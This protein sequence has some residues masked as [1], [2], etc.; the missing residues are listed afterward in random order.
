MT[1]RPVQPTVRAPVAAPVTAGGGSVMDWLRYIDRVTRLAGLGVGTAASG[2]MAPLNLIPGVRDWVPDVGQTPEAFRAFRELQKA[3]DWDAAIKAYQDELEAGKYF[4]GGAEALGAFIPTGGPALAGLG[5]L[6][7]AP[8]LASTVARVAPRVARPAVQRGV[9]TAVRGAGQTLR[10]PWRAEEYATRQALR[11]VKAG[12]RAAAFSRPGAA[13]LGRAAQTPVG[14]GLPER[15]GGRQLRKFT[16]MAGAAGDPLA[17]LKTKYPQVRQL[18]SLYSDIEGASRTAEQNFGSGWAKLSQP[19]K[20]DKVLLQLEETTG[21]QRYQIPRDLDV[22]DVVDDITNTILKTQKTVAPKKVIPPPVKTDIPTG[23]AVPTGT[24]VPTAA[25]PMAVTGLTQVGKK[26]TVQTDAGPMSIRDWIKNAYPNAEIGGTG[27]QSRGDRGLLDDVWND[28]S[29]Q[30]KDALINTIPFGQIAPNAFIDTGLI[31]AG[32]PVTKKKPSSFM[33]KDS[34]VELNRWMDENEHPLR[35]IP[36]KAHSAN[37]LIDHR[38][39]ETI[40]QATPQPA[41]GVPTVTAAQQVDGQPALFD[42]EKVVKEA[43]EEP[44]SPITPTVTGEAIPIA[45]AAKEVVEAGGKGKKPPPPPEAEA[46]ARWEQEPRKSFYKQVMPDLTN[47]GLLAQTLFRGDLGRKIANTA[48]MRNIVSRINPSAT[49]KSVEERGLVILGNMMEE[50]QRK[51]GLVMSRL[52]RIGNHDQLFGKT[53]EMGRLMGMSETDPLRG[54]YLYDVIQNINKKNY[55]VP[56]RGKKVPIKSL[57]KGSVRDQNGRII[58][59]LSLKRRNW[60]NEAFKITNAKGRFLDR[61]EIDFKRLNFVDGGTYFGRRQLAGKF[62]VDGELEEI[63]EIVA[64]KKKVAAKPSAFKERIYGSQRE[65][66]RDGFR[67]MN[68][69][70]ALS[71]NVTAAYNHAA[72]TRVAN[73]LVKNSDNLVKIPKKGKKAIGGSYSKIHNFPQLSKQ[74]VFVGDEHKVLAKKVSDALD[75]NISGALTAVNKF[76]AV[77]RFMVL[78]GDAS[79]FMIQL[80]FLAG[81]NP[82]VWGQAVRGFVNGMFDPKYHANLTFNSRRV[83]RDHPNLILA[84]RPGGTEL[85]EAA[86]R[87][88]LLNW[89]VFKPVGT[90]LSPFVRGFNAAMDSAGLGMAKAMEQSVIKGTR[91]GSV[92]RATRLRDLDS[93]IN[94]LRGLASSASLGVKPK[95]R[96]LESA[97]LLAPRYTRAIAALMWDTVNIKDR[98][99]RARYTRRTMGQAVV[100]LMSINLAFSIAEYMQKS[101]NPTQ[102]GLIDF[103]TDKVNPTSPR[104]FTWE[105]NGTNVGPGTKVRSLVRFAAKGITDF[106]SM[107]PFSDEAGHNPFTN[108]LRGQASPLVS[109]AVDM[110]TGHNYIGEPTGFFDNL[111]DDLVTNLAQTGKEIVLPDIMPIWIQ[112]VML[113]GGTLSEKA[114]RGVGEFFGLRAYPLGRTQQAEEVAR[115]LGY[116]DYENQNMRVKARIDLIVK[117]RHGEEYRGRK[118]PLYEK[119][120]K[121]EEDFIKGVTQISDQFLTA[122]MQSAKWSPKLARKGSPEL[123]MIGLDD[124]REE[125]IEKLFGHWDKEKQRTVGGVHE[126]LYNRDKE[127]PEPEAGTREDIINRYYEVFDKATKTGS[128]NLDWDAL[129]EELSMFWSSLTPEQAN[130]LLDNIRVIEDQYPQPVRN[131]LYA[132]RYAGQYKVNI[133]GQTGNYYDLKTHPMVLQYITGLTGVDEETVRQFINLS[134]YERDAAAKQDPAKTMAKALAKAEAKKGILWQMRREFVNNASNEWVMAMMH[135]DYSY[136]GSKKINQNLFDHLSGGGELPTYDYEALYRQSI[137]QSAVRQAA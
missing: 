116:A 37:M 23:A 46:L 129:D 83:I 78:N 62:N 98:G 3:G 131:M 22:Y 53:D 113:E 88:G 125:R 80:L 61:N 60:I 40:Q 7:A 15:L 19:E 59:G 2:V 4:W 51:S 134:K 49:A 122:P 91:R 87:G 136:Q 9:E 112:S 42:M 30:D 110:L 119:A 114:T 16:P 35:D 95:H 89:G 63:A 118:G 5:L 117:E 128:G 109:D 68:A 20:A 43:T 11:P 120:D 123:D 14:R 50:G 77:G 64:G 111:D 105:I 6:K 108:F 57:F 107:N 126:D 41:T 81:Q 71:A 69:D 24:A 52:T 93:Y 13:A 56:L 130:E 92:E 21:L 17:Q 67:P 100:A 33:D 48:V 124:L 90:A 127:M 76:N 36:S 94:N 86:S 26:W 85:V 96:A 137:T 97:M 102:E 25:V 31:K 58:Q 84:S 44:I 39:M 38:W 82:R 74:A 133:Q 1:T 132:G 12:V 18:N 79:P 115:E 10:V 73:W 72:R 28:L 66:S 55:M 101:E 103:L 65:A 106:S 135:A 29:L 27:I 47:E 104:F 99:L 34:K 121:I 54:Q 45:K 32:I 70:E 75:P 8:K